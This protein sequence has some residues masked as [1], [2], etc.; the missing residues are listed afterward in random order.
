V[1]STIGRSSRRPSS[2]MI[3]RSLVSEIRPA[4]VAREQI[5]LRVK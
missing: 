2:L 4:G 5:R 1:S 3:S